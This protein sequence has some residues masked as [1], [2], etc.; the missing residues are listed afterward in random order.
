MSRHIF[1]YLSFSGL[2]ACLLMISAP[3]EA[4]SWKVHVSRD[5]NGAVEYSF[6]SA[7]APEG[8]GLALMCKPS[9]QGPVWEA[10]FTS[11]SSHKRF[12]EGRDTAYVYIETKELLFYTIR[13]RKGLTTE[14]SIP[15]DTSALLV[16][17]LKTTETL[18]LGVNR[19][20][21]AELRLPGKVLERAEQICRDG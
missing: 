19:D 14:G 18:R 7:F 2:F 15:A 6:L 21:L 17:R 10:T 5:D 1:K 8:Y 4:R 12:L 13:Q 9:S 11:R 3:S 20:E 16:E